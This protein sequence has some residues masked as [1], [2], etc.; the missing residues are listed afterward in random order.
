MATKLSVR[1][2]YEETRICVAI[3]LSVRPLWKTYIAAY[4]RKDD[5]KTCVL[6]SIAALIELLSKEH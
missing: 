5:I 2:R 3:K 1:P 6:N 4:M